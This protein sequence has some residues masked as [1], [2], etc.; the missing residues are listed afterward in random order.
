MDPDIRLAGLISIIYRSHSIALNAE[1]K[2]FCLSAGQ[3]LVLIHLSK[4]QNI[5]QEDLAQHFHIDK[6]T[7]ARAV[8]SLEDAGYI[9]RKVDQSNRRA[10][11]L[12]LTDDGKKIIPDILRIERQLEEIACDGLSEEERDQLL[13][14]LRKVAV[15]S[16][17]HVKDSGD[18]EYAHKWT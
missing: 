16:L 13:A 14:L 6:S 17:T 3:F 11:R 2:Q 1:M 8:R 5:M 10:V 15:N 9:L 12:F 18:G 7:I 4:E